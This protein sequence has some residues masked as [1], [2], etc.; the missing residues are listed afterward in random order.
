VRT[1]LTPGGTFVIQL[2]SD[3]DVARRRL[4]GRVEHVMSGCSEPF[5]SLAGLLAF[6]GRYA[7]AEKARTSAAE[8]KDEEE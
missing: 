5:T 3:S 2:R 1:S 6:I 4:S 7:E 8:P